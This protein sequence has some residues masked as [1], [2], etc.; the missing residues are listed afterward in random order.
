VGDTAARR[1]RRPSSRGIA[2]RRRVDGDRGA[3][4]CATI[5]VT[6]RTARTRTRTRLATLPF[7]DRITG[8]WNGRLTG[9]RGGRLRVRGESDDAAL[10]PRASTTFGFCATRRG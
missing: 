10:A 4:S 3:G 6:D 5:T 2:V 9:R 7:R 1:R 8:R